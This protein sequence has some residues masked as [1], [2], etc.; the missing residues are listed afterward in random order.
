MPFDGI[1]QSRINS[2]QTIPAINQDP[3]AYNATFL[4]SWHDPY[5]SISNSVRQ[6]DH[7]NTKDRFIITINVIDKILHSDLAQAQF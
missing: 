1:I 2:L 3:V 5:K 4:L 6:W 7:P